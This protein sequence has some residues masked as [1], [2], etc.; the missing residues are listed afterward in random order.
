MKDY[1]N[2]FLYFSSLDESAVFFGVRFPGNT[3]LTEFAPDE[4]GTVKAH[5]AYHEKNDGAYV[6]L[7]TD[8]ILGT[9]ETIIVQ[10]RFYCGTNKDGPVAFTRGNHTG[11]DE[12]INNIQDYKSPVNGIE[13]ILYT[14]DS[15][16]SN[17]IFSLNDV[18]YSLS[19]F[20]FLHSESN[21][22]EIF[23]NI[24]DAFE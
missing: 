5:I 19:D 4:R 20:F 8:Y 16:I 18:S 13:A 22:Y 7:F 21:S 14:D 15:G 17:A 6:D 9:G 2:N 12:E 10:Y 24:I 11:F 23:K 1:Q 3:I